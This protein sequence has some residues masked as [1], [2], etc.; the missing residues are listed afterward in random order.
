MVRCALLFGCVWGIFGVVCWLY[1]VMFIVLSR[2]L[3]WWVV[4][5]AYVTLPQSWLPLGTVRG[6]VSV[7]NVTLL[8]KL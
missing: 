7:M 5:I 8:F 2:M 6:K 1:S 4:L 3:W